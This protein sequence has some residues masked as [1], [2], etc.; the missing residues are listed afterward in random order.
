M[1][2]LREVNTFVGLYLSKASA[3]AADAASIEESP[4]TKLL[5]LATDWTGSAQSLKNIAAKLKAFRDEN[6]ELEMGVSGRPFVAGVSSV[7]NAF[8]K[9]A[10]V[11]CLDCCKEGMAVHSQ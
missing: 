8:R 11:L 5:H 2:L 1:L 4:P 6:A 9:S 3:W 10:G 7:L